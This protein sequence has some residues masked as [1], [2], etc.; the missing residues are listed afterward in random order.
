MFHAL[1]QGTGLGR[2]VLQLRRQ[3]EQAVGHGRV[4]LVQAG[5][6]PR[7]LGGQRQRFP[8]PTP[9][10]GEGFVNLA[11][12]AGDRLGVLRR[13][14][15]R[16]DLGG[17]SDAQLGLLDLASLMLL[18]LQTPGQLTGIERELRQ[19]RLVGPPG[20]HGRGHRRA[21][22]LQT[23]ECIQQLALPALVQETLLVV[24][25]VDLHEPTCHFGQPG[26]RNGLVIYPRGRSTGRG[27]LPN[28]YQRLRNAVEERLDAGRLGPV[29]HERRVGA[30]AGGETQ[31]VDQKALAG[32]GLAGEDVEAGLEHDPEPLDQGQVS[33]AQLRQSTGGHGRSRFLRLR[34]GLPG[35]LHLGSLRHEG[36]SSDF[37]RSRS[38]KG[39]A[40]LG[41]IRRIGRPISHTATTSP[42]ANRLSSRP[43][44]LMSTS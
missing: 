31:R 13:G 12:T 9:L 1:S 20:F 17:L 27:N 16:P 33:N 14:Q 25:S 18:Q 15:F 29:A 10:P 32:A 28:A 23:P 5:Q 41:S 34:R 7:P 8:C 43:S 37:W 30:S 6:L 19:D 4:A 3:P 11:T 24:L 42:I 36:S 40:P 21:P 35:R 22:L 44:T 39:T 26:R 2:G 38:Q